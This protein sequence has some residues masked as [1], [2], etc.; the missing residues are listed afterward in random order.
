MSRT[1]VTLAIETSNP[2]AL[3]P[4][5]GGVALRLEG[6]IH[7]EPVAAG[8]H[9]DL[10][11]AID[12]LF[13]RT[14]LT[15]SDLGLIAVSIGP[16]GF[17]ALRVCVTVAKVL[18]FTSGAGCVG[19]P[20]ASALALAARRD[21]HESSPPRS[22]GVLLASKGNSSHATVFPEGSGTP[23]QQRLI[24]APDLASLGVGT[25]IA[26]Q[27][28][29]LPIRAEAERLGIEIRP[30]RFDASVVLEV[31][32]LLHAQHGSIEPDALAPIYPREPEAVT[33]WRQLHPDS[34]G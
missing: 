32:E 5:G 31:G 15:P 9:D 13:R 27:F 2:S 25:L 26:D 23:S 29:P 20:T 34:H 24:E 1:P 16:G 22:I 18:A 17:T 28:V 10:M 12:R 4:G 19:V 33:K 7:H 14:K 30:P 11:P 3:G 21:C 6:S 8:R